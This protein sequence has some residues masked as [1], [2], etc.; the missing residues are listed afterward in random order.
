MP[1][2]I[3][4]VDPKASFTDILAELR[5]L[6]RDMLLAFRLQV[7]KLL[8]DRFYDGDIREYRNA[9]DAEFLMQLLR[10]CRF[11]CGYFTSSL[12]TKQ[13]VFRQNNSPN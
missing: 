6:S 8:L 11:I 5:L 9:P 1:N 12:K 3:E 7:G 13:Q 4:L 10:D 2:D